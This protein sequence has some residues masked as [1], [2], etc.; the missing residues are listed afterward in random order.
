MENNYN[1][2]ENKLFKFFLVATIIVPSINI[3]G[4]VIIGFPIQMNIKWVI[5]IIITSILI[6]LMKSNIQ[7]DYLKLIYFLLIILF[8]LP[9]GWRDSGSSNT[10][11]ITY[12]FLIMMCITF[13]FSKKLRSILLIL[14]TLVV[15]SLFILEYNFPQLIIKYDDKS[16]FLDRII[17]VPLTLFGGFLILKQFSDAHRKDNEKL[18]YF[19]SRDVLTGVFNRRIFNNKLKEIIENKTYI[20]RSIFVILVDIDFFKYINDTKGHHVGDV[21]INHIAK[22]LESIL[23]DY[24]ILSRWGGDEFAIIFFGEEE[25]LESL[26]KQLYINIR[27]KKILEDLEIT[28]SSGITK[29]IVYDDINEILRRADKALYESKNRGRNMY[30]FA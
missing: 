11:A 7:L 12:V 30:T 29:I 4:N 21:V 6:R 14:L 28:L 27:D 23:P 26:M 20:D 25:E 16:V 5:V 19:A 24:C 8:I 2:L 15:I 18:E 13:F 10:V 17:Q 22:Q 1:K 9:L 3:I